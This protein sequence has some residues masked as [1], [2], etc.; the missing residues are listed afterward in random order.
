MLQGPKDQPR[1]AA[2]LFGGQCVLPLAAGSTSKTTYSCDARTLP[3]TRVWGSDE[4]NLHSLSATAPLRIELRWRCEESSEKTAAGSGVTFKYEPFGRRIEKVSPSST[5]IFVYDGDNLV[6]TLNA[7]GSVVAHYAQGQGIDEPLA[8]ERGST[9]DYY[10]ADGLGSISSL[11]ASTGSIAQTYTYDSFG[12]QTASSGSLTNFFR[13][14]AREFD[15][16]TNLYYDRARYYDPGA[17]R[18]ISEDPIRFSGGVNFYAYVENR[19]LY[20]TDPSGT[21]PEP[22]RLK[23]CAENYYGIGSAA[24]R[25]GTL[26]AAAPVPKSW[27]GLPSALGSGSTTTLPSVFSLGGGT[28][29]SGVNLFRIAGRAAGPVAVASVAIDATALALCTSNAPLPNFLYTIAKYDPF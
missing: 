21:C 4:K 20:F 25:L 14:A 29:A 19:P 24:T 16:E 11:T 2:A 3:E 9:T 6:E 27:F 12:N 17:S 8:M 23:V 18:F 7:S 1:V 26:M 5:S 15:T 22:N 13:Y 28:A 10:E